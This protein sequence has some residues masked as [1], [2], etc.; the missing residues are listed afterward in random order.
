MCSKETFSEVSKQV[1]PSATRH[2]LPPTSEHAADSGVKY[3][4]S[5]GLLGSGKYITNIQKVMAILR[6]HKTDGCDTGKSE[7]YK[8]SLH[9][10]WMSFNDSEYRDDTVTCLT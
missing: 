5:S 10:S 1:I 8:H 6:Y 9:C 4:Y 7:H 2:S 3:Q